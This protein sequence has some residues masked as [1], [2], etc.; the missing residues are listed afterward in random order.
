[1]SMYFDPCVKDQT[2]MVLFTIAFVSGMLLTAMLIICFNGM[3]RRL[4][5]WLFFKRKVYV[6]EGQLNSMASSRLSRPSKKM[7]YMQDLL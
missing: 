2:L 4:V 5:E 7:K 3:F 1:M 6:F